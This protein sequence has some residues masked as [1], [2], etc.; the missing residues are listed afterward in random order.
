LQHFA[1]PHAN[2]HYFGANWWF[3][4]FRMNTYISA[5]NKGLYLPLE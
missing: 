5:Q 3:K 4:S 1:K 2:V